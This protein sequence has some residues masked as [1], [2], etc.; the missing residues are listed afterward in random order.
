VF[1]EGYGWVPVAF[2]YSTGCEE[3]EINTPPVEPEINDCS[4]MPL[5]QLEGVYFEDNELPAAVIT[6]TGEVETNAETGKM[7]QPIL[8]NQK[9]MRCWFSKV[10][11]VIWY[12][13][14]YTGVRYKDNGNDA[15]WKFE[16]VDYSA[17][18]TIRRYSTTLLRDPGTVC[19]ITGGCL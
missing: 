5:D 3:D 7:R 12:S 14:F 18:R 17:G 13:M 8:I 11:N 16:T 9:L 10:S 2:L 4:K 19:I 1:F 15:T 6:S